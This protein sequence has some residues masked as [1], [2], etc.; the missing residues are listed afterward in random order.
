MA[1]FLF[2]IRSGTKSSIDAEG[3]EFPD[4]QAAR[5]DAE[6]LSLEL[7]REDIWQASDAD[8]N[9]IEI[10]DFSGHQLE[11]VT[12]SRVLKLSASVIPVFGRP[13]LQH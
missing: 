13:L 12:L 8:I 3:S 4:L 7:I 2:N 1:L 9:D 11:L 5:E 6:K 10:C